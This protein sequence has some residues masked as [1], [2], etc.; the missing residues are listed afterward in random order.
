MIAYIK[1]SKTSETSRSFENNIYFCPVQYNLLLKLT[2]RKFSSRYLQSRARQQKKFTR[3]MFHRGRNK[4]T[5]FPGFPPTRPTE[6]ERGWAGGRI[7]ENPGNE[8]GN[9][10]D[11]GEII[12]KA[13]NFKE[14]AK[15]PSRIKTIVSRKFSRITKAI[16]EQKI[17][18]VTDGR[19]YYS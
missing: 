16:S 19:V 14:R 12:S 9:K 10:R 2:S 5:S 6:R 11:L 17:S 18:H 4:T 3:I 13:S 7:G 1:V 8:V 15:F